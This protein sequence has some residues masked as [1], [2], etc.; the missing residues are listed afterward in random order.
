[1]RAQ[2]QKAPA[3]ILEV[4]KK[5]KSVGLQHCKP[6]S[7][8]CVLDAKDAAAH[9]TEHTFQSIPGPTNWPL[10]GN[11]VDILRRGGLQK[12]HQTLVPIIILIVLF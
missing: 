10:L 1:M 7:S 9:C 11:L 12:Q 6:T 5:K 2:I 3:Q 4:L 8:V